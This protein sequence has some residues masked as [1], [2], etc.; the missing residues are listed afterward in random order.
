MY[1]VGEHFVE[2]LNGEES[3]V[4]SEESRAKDI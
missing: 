4:T 1:V 3:P 2:D